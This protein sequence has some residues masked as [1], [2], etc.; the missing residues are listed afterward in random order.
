[1]ES[2]GIM[3]AKFCK[4]NKKAIDARKMTQVNKILKGLLCEQWVLLA[5]ALPLSF[6]G[7]L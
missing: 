4:E 7:S 5:F 1:V 6:L 2:A 3:C